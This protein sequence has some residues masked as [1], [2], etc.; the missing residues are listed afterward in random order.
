MCIFDC[1]AGVQIHP[2]LH[3]HSCLEDPLAKLKRE[4]ELA[5]EEIKERERDHIRVP[6]KW[7]I[8]AEIHHCHSY[9]IFQTLANQGH[10]LTRRV[11]EG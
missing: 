10:D 7:K 6:S 4:I 9:A 5:M 3:D 8:R 2:S 11:V 1:F